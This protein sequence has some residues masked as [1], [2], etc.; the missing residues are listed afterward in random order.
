MTDDACEEEDVVVLD[1]D[2]D[3]PAKGTG[4]RRDEVGGNVSKRAN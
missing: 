4:K 2:D 1:D 3:L